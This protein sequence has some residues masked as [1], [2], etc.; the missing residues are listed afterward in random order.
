[1]VSGECLVGVGS[2]S[3]RC[4]GECMQRMKMG[5]W[6]QTCNFNL[7]TGQVMTGHDKRVSGQ[8]KLGQSG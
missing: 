4:L 8:F 7:R 2:V 3:G 6:R 5:I 1:M